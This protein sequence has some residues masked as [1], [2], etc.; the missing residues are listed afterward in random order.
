RV[1]RPPVRRLLRGRARRSGGHDQRGVG[2]GRLQAGH[3]RGARRL[4]PPRVVARRRADR[5]G[6]RRPTHGLLRRR[7]PAGRVLSAAA[8]VVASP[9]A[10][11]EH[12]VSAVTRAR[13]EA[14]FP[15]NT[16][17]AYSRVWSG[18]VEWC[19]AAGRGALPATA[20]TLAEY[21][22]RLCDEGKA[23]ATIRQA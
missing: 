21:T 8:L 11:A 16:R 15:E 12:T 9:S 4:P 13:I 3:G 18:F 20:E 7:R 5:R 17:R 23:P 10:V 19:A 6:A 2:R 1:R 14:S 22:S